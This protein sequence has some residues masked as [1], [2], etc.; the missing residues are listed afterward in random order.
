[1]NERRVYADATALIGLAR[2]DRL[3]ILSLLPLPIYVTERV[4]QEVASDAEKAGAAALL[5]A[6]EA[7]LLAV[8][9]EG[10][11]DA[12]P[13]LDA[14]ENTV[15]TAAAAAGAAV[16]LDERKAR[17]LIESDPYLKAQ[18][19][20][21]TGIVGLILLAKRRGLIPAVRPLLDALI[22]QNFWLSPT[23]YDSVL[24]E[25]GEG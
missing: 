8:V 11:P 9:D 13:Q 23:F 3:D 22:G 18:I 7:G 19:R 24:H 4:W 15:L 10:D 5:Q 2:I 17:R 16:L 1:L 12:F 14:G 6:R 21:A 20:A 25:A